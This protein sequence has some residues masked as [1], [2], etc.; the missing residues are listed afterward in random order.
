MK[1]LIAANDFDL[2]E[3]VVEALQYVNYNIGK[4]EMAVDDKEVLIKMNNENYDIIILDMS[5]LKIDDNDLFSSIVLS[6]S[7]KAIFLICN[8]IPENFNVRLLSFDT[9][10]FVNKSNIFPEITKRL[11]IILDKSF[12]RSKL[13]PSPIYK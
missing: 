1:V 4:T 5:V 3:S 8:Q 13:K 2:Q 7:L 10:N 9:L 11:S 12:V 6:E